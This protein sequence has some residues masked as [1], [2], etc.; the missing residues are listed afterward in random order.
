MS[1]HHDPAAWDRLARGTGVTGLLTIPLVFVPTIA[2]STLGEP[3]LDARA[4]ETV[5][6]L[7]NLA[8]SSWAPVAS[9]AQS[10]AVLVLLWWA[11]AFTHVMR[12]AEG[13]PSWRSTA[14]LASIVILAGHVVLESSFQAAVH[15]RDPEP[16]LALFA[17]ESGNL[18]FANSWLALGSFA[19]ACG[20]VIISTRMLAPGLG[21]LAVVS[22]AG[23]VV[24]RIFWTSSLWLLPYAAFWI[25]VVAVSVSLLRR[26]RVRA[27]PAA[28]PVTAP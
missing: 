11:A 22:G 1:T 7:T 25:W 24:A 23:F 28:T 2:L 27:T 5:A 12:R 4:D 6:F 16:E 13:E 19:V 8:E 9:V 17:F 26:S 15:L 10:V 21:W 14:A 18:G 20:W 3:P